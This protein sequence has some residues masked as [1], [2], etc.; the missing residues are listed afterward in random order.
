MLQG[1]HHGRNIRNLSIL[2]K[3]LVV[4]DWM[5]WTVS[6][7]SRS[8]IRWSRTIGIK[9]LLLPLPTH[10]SQ[11]WSQFQCLYCLLCCCYSSRNARMKHCCYTNTCLNSYHC[12]QLW[13]GNEWCKKATSEAYLL[14]NLSPQVNQVMSKADK[15]T[16]HHTCVRMAV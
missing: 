16:D 1:S 5:V 3:N 14:C 15:W 9:G 10:Y 4:F 6:W 13:E 12:Y 8:R 11:S 2:V 7:C